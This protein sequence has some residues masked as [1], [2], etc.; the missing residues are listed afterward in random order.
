MLVD[1]IVKVDSENT[2]ALENF[3]A[4]RVDCLHHLTDPQPLGPL[5]QFRKERE[6]GE[7]DAFYGDGS[8]YKQ[9]Q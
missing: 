4:L 2:T 9:D 6:T 7:G 1:K 5:L 3:I 8:F